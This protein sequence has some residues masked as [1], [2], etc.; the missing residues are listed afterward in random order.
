MIIFVE[1]IFI[2]IVGFRKLDYWYIFWY[3]SF[4]LGGVSWR[5]KLNGFLTVIK[6]CIRSSVSLTIFFLESDTIKKMDQIFFQIF[7]FTSK[8]DLYIKNN[9]I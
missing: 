2:Y 6:I 3:W 5:N 7:D 1:Y 9:K 4:L 8:F